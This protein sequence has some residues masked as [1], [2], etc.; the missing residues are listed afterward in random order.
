MHPVEQN[1]IRIYIYIN[2]YPSLKF[3]INQKPEHMKNLRIC[4]LILSI[5]AGLNSYVTAQPQY[6]NFNTN[7]SNNSFPFG[8]A[9]GKNVEL[10]YLPGDFNQP[11]PAPNGTITAIGFR[12]GDTYPINGFQYTTFTIDLGQAPGLTSFPAGAYYAGTMTNVYNHA[13]VT[14][15]A[16]GGTWLIITLDTPFPYDNTQ[17]LIMRIGHCGSSNATGFPSCFTAGTGSRRNWSVGGCPFVYSSQNTSIYHVGLNITTGVPPAVITTAA[18][19]I[20]TNTATLNGTV[21]ANGYSTTVTF[22]YGLTTAYGTTVPGVPGTVT[23]NTVTPVSANISGLTISTLYHYRV[24]GVNAGGTVNGNDMTFTTTNCPLPAAPGTITG[25]TSLCGN[26]TG[27]IYSVVAIPGVTGYSWT[28]PPGA[29]ITAGSN[30][31]SITVTFGNT[32]GNVTVCGINVCGNGPVSTL[33]ITVTPVPVPVING[34]SSVCINSGYLYYSTDAGM[35]NY[36][37]TISS[38]GTIVAGQGTN[39]IQV[40]WNGAGSQSISVIYATPTG[41]SPTIPTVLPVSVITVPGNAGTITGTASTCAGATGIAYSVSPVTNAGAYVW[42]LPAGATIATGASTN[43]ITVDFALNASSG[44][45]TV[46]ANN[47]CGNGGT[48][49]SFA[50][51]VNPKP[52]APVITNTGYILYSSA[53]AG[54]QWYFEGTL[55]PGATGQTHDATTTGTGYYWSVVTINGCSSDQSNHQMVISTGV[56]SK[57]GAGISL[58]PVPNDGKFTVTFTGFSNETYT[59]SVINNIGV[60]IFEESKVKV[61]GPTQKVIDLRPVPSGVYTVIFENS[62]KQVVKKI[63]VNK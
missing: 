40:T 9:A 24:I 60:K 48:S 1:D 28:V 22:E 2:R 6:Y 31:N 42:T 58:N 16:T 5:I 34:Q 32:S 55:I 61:D 44:P 17:S 13:S 26:S 33:A 47:M 10:L 53:P 11:T 39:Q 46:Y 21:N 23:G 63:V 25:P 38:G 18:T 57:S 19:A 56:E 52:P 35:N 36:V 49:P 41:C 8:I 3:Y 43:S 50:V 29:M 30:T 14:F 12:V 27:K 51:T 54:N 4:V 37:W 15:T 45:I 20:S 59:I 62:Q 7:G